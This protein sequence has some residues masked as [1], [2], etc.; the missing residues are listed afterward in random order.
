M[1][2]M[3]EPRNSTSTAQKLAYP[4]D[5]RVLI[6]NADDFGMRSRDRGPGIIE[7]YSRSTLSRTELS[8][9]PRDARRRE[10]D[11]RFFS[12]ERARTLSGNQGIERFGYRKL[13]DAPQESQG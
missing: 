6:V 7:I 1:L 11:F 2:L 5:T 9:C 13:R 4:K 3:S 10:A 12:S 8:G